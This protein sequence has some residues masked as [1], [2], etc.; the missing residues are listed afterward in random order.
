MNFNNL[1]DNT[2]LIVNS[3]EKNNIISKLSAEGG[4]FN[5][6][7]MTLNELRN[8]L[9]FS[10]DEK[11][12]YYLMSK[13]G[14]KYDVCLMYL[15][16]LYYVSNEDFGSN[17]LRCLIN[18][19][20]ELIDNKLLIFDNFFKKS[21]KDRNIVIYNYKFKSK[22]DKSIIDELKKITSV[23][24]YNDINKKYEHKYIYE[25]QNIEEEV[26]FIAESIVKLINDG[27]DV[28]DIKICG[29]SDK[30]INMV[31][32]IF[33]LYK[34]PIVFNDSSLFATKIGQDFLN[35]FTNNREDN[36]KYI[37]DKYNIL[38]EGVLN[39]YNKIVDIVNKY[40]W[41]DNILSVKDIIIHDFKNTKVNV[42]ELSYAV[43]VVSSLEIV[44]SKYVFLVSFCQ[45]CIPVIYKNEDY[46]DDSIKDKLGIDTS[47]SL[48]K[49]SYD[50]WLNSILSC[51]NLVISYS[52]FDS[53]GECYLSSLNDELKLDIIKPCFT[54]K[55][56]NLYNKMKLAS[57]IDELIKYN[58]K[59]LE[60]DILYNN[61]KDINYMVYDNKYSN[62][63]KNNLKKYI[64]NKLNLSYSV[65]NDY[66]HCSFK[67]YLSNIL[68]LNFYEETFFTILGN[69]FHYILSIC[70]NKDV[71]VKYEYYKFIKEQEYEFN[72][73]ELFFLDNLFFELLFVIDTIKKQYEKSG[74]SKYLYEQKIEINKSKDDMEIV[75]KG[76]IDKLILDDNKSVCTIVDY[77]T[78]SADINLG[79]SIYGLD[80][81]LPV[82]LYLTKHK[83]NDIRIIGFY[84]QKVINNEISISDKK[85]YLE[86][87]EDNLKLSGY[88]NKDI[89][90]VS[91][92]DNTY[93]DSKVIK[94]FRIGT[95]GILS[96]KV[97][98]DFEIDS[99]I[100]L[101][102]NKINDAIENILEANFNINPKRVGKDNIGCKYCSYKDICFVREKDILSY[103][104]H[105]DM[106]FLELYN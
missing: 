53:S 104:E 31:K 29:I 101:T 74:L 17:K 91:L 62:I 76:F 105:K 23:T 42:L 106:D 54:Y 68:K 61:Y 100:K 13:Y 63:D 67:Y 6:K 90:L 50:R 16:N 72:D 64:K 1:R 24:I 8:K 33:F 80:L 44:S 69:L 57:D 83:F 39:I 12:I 103:K 32:R 94:G 46:L 48:N 22:Y 30:Y 60:L 98:D 73:K 89:N 37:Y 18:I 34:I 28:N 71:D 65:I 20:K 97:L 35:N 70:F 19:K 66:Y 36:L 3:W 7:I 27:I 40:A 59:T 49:L 4:F 14:Y 78:G 86:L 95:K 51:E 79:N 88:T 82:Y 21:I 102:D 38:D 55:Y 5:I 92:F 43:E 87:K 52:K 56:S 15:E 96:K 41:C 75:F 25:C 26:V 93:L 9:Y 99:L 85:N 77:K 58:E 10:Y 81:Q 45:G 11:A 2:I 47:I 84:L